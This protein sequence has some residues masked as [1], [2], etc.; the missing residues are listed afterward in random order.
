MGGKNVNPDSQ[1]TLEE[2]VAGMEDHEYVVQILSTPV[3]TSTLKEW[4]PRTERD[5][6]DWNGQL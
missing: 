5:M 6:T 2:S 3:F 1:R 4:A